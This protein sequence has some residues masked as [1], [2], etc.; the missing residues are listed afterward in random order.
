MMMNKE[1]FYL[2]DIELCKQLEPI[3][4][5]K[6]IFADRILV[7]ILTPIQGKPIGHLYSTD[8]LNGY[9]RELVKKKSIAVYPTYRKDSLEAALPDMHFDW[10][11]IYNDIKLKKLVI[12][13]QEIEPGLAIVIWEY[14]REFSGH[15]NRNTKQESLKALGELIVLLDTELDAPSGAKEGI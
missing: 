9:E 6:G 10:I 3:M 2:K 13:D 5:K 15:H 7:N 12:R 1:D 4:K 14:W 8:K 11:A